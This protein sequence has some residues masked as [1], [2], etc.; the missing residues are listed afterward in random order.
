MSEE[1]AGVEAP[2]LTHGTAT[3]GQLV[4]SSKN[5]VDSNGNITAP[6]ALRALSQMPVRGAIAMR[7][8]KLLR[9]VEVEVQSFE[10]ARI[11]LMKSLGEQVGEED[12]WK[13]TPENGAEYNKQLVEMR[14]EPFALPCVKLHTS[15]L[16]DANIAAAELMALDWLFA[17]E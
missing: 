5:T 9:A 6:S 7:I 11:E 13:F 14:A 8:A 15:D 12:L 3:V 16:G 4:D 1:N 2:T 17:E 10:K